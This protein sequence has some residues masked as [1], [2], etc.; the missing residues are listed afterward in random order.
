VTRFLKNSFIFKNGNFLTQ[1]NLRK[2][3]PRWF[4]RENEENVVWTRD[5]CGWP[6]SPRCS[7]VLI[8]WLWVTLYTL[9]TL[10]LRRLI[11]LPVYAGWS[12]FLFTRVDLASCLRGLILLPVY[13]GW[14]CFLFTRVDLAS[15]L[16]G[17]ILLPVY[18]GWSCF[19]FTQVDLAY[20]FSFILT[21]IEFG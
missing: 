9:W 19:L 8:T 16:R 3:I 7:V 20:N 2:R 5:W 6:F 15:C 1:N 11:L 17:L 12:C 18:A 10:V 14:S 4:G 13:A 21:I